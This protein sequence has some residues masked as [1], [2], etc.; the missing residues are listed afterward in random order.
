MILGGVHIKMI[1]RS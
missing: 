1:L